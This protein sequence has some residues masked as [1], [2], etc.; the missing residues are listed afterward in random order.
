MDRNERIGEELGKLLRTYQLS[1]AG[2]PEALVRE[3]MERAKVYFEAVEIYEV[4]DVAGAVQNM[5]NGSAPG[6]NPA[7][8]PPAP[9]VAAETRRVM[10]LR[11][12]SERREKLARPTLPPPDIEHTPE[13]RARVAAMAA[14]LAARTARQMEAEDAPRQ[15]RMTDLEIRTRQRFAPD[16]S[17]TAVRKRLRI[18]VGDPDGEPA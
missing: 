11:L 2:D 1:Q 14:A 3:R 5:L 10:N 16:M 17:P 15:A 8:I 9:L 18:D 7:F 13:S 6:F 4:R 12:D